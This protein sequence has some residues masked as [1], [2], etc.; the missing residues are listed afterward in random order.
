MSVSKIKC[1]V[2]LDGQLFAYGNGRLSPL[3]E[4]NDLS[5]N[6]Y[7]ITDLKQGISKAMTIEAPVR[8]VELMARRKLQESGEFE[9]PVTILTHWKKARGKNTTDIFFTAIPTR[10]SLYYTE[11][12][13]ERDDAVMVFPI[14]T[15]LFNSIKRLKTKKPV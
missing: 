4:I 14:Y 12:L 9:E 15:L 1:A 3:Q 7:L 10:L 6:H 13:S 5:G 2:E 11:H 8:Y